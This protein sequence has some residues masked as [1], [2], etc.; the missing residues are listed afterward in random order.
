MATR[1]DGPVVAPVADY[2]D[3]V[4]ARDVTG[5]RAL[6]LAEL[7][8]GGD[9][10]RW[11]IEALLVPAM[12]EVGA[13]WYDGRWNAAQEHVASGI[14]ESALSA[15]SVRARSRR[16]AADSPTVVVACPRGEAHVLAARFAAELLAEAGAD[17]IALGLPVPDRDLADYL[18]E[19]RPDALVLSC[20][21]P[22][23]LPGARDAVAAAHGVGVPVLAG[24]AG[25]GP[26]DRRARVL[27][28]DGWA[29][30]PE[31]GLAVLRSWRAQ[32]PELAVATAEDREVGALQRLRDS[33]VDDVLSALIR[34]VY[35]VGRYG[36]REVEQA[37]G[38]LRLIVS[39]L[40]CAL[41]ADDERLFVEFATWGR[42]LLEARS[43]PA[44][45]L[46]ESLAE[47][48]DALGPG[49]PR[50]HG[51]LAAARARN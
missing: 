48:G 16:P 37:R 2:L 15:A 27:G 50:T 39:S 44:A 41:L 7:R 43:V 28:A 32:P 5:A 34:R 4:A 9:G 20:T 47:I 42:G 31:E 13:R 24:G 35:V 10:L 29:R 25:L 3:R 17:V 1:T 51:L 19:V 22:L 23:A 21:E 18:V 33:F 14:T 12:T 11:V 36:E 45:V 26:D 38:D 8:S 40:A 6:V 49:F 46:D 30:R